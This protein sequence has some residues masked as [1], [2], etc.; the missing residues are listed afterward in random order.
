MNE[1]SFDPIS[2]LVAIIEN[3]LEEARE[4]T[5]TDWE[6]SPLEII[7]EI[8]NSFVGKSGELFVK[9]I[10][11]DNGCIIK[12]H[13]ARG[14]YDL[15]VRRDQ[16]ERKVEVKTATMDTHR[17][18]QFNG[19]RE[20]R[21]YDILFVLGVSPK[22]I[23]FNIYTKDEVKCLQKVLIT[24]NILNNYKVTLREEDLLGINFFS[25]EIEKIL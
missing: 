9:K 20:D 23:F 24:K 17:K 10:F 22:Y 1:K 3:V 19:V 7:K 18:F 14:E 6:G 21:E 5:I 2:T 8:P 13:I 12:K 16:K 4:K 15:L 25:T 11:E